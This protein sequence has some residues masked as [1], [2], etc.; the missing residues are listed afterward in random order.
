MAVAYDKWN[1]AYEKHLFIWA[2]S[3][4]VFLSA[5]LQFILL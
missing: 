4:G 3:R 2:Y 1:A 5:P